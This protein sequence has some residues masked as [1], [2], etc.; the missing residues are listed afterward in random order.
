MKG[1]LGHRTNGED[2]LVFVPGIGTVIA[3]PHVRNS[4]LLRDWE[5]CDPSSTGPFSYGPSVYHDAMKCA[6]RE[7]QPVGLAWVAALTT[8]T[9]N[10]HREDG[11]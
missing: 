8:A 9:V 4:L 1:D 10:A 5:G 11:S 2:H 6:A 7:N 3:D